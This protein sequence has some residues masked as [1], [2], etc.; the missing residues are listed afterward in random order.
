MALGATSADTLSRRIA[1]DGPMTIYEAGSNKRELLEALAGS[2]G[3]EI[4]LFNVDEFDTAGLQLLV[5]VQREALKAGKPVQLAGASA[6]VL[7]VL[8]RYGLGTRFGDPAA[9]PL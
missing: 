4:D 8:D 2:R 1:I 9:P 7:E 5:L 6:A 3:L